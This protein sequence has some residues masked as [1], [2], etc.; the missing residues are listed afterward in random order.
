MHR[1]RT[2]GFLALPL[3]LLGCASLP[4]S[5][6]LRTEA[7]KN[8][9]FSMVLENPKAYVGTI[10]LWGG[11][12]I[13]TVNLKEGTEIFLL[14]TPLDS[15]ER[16]EGGFSSRGRFIAKDSNFLDPAVYKKNRWITLAGEVIGEKTEAL[17][18]TEYTYPVVA[19]K[20]LHLWKRPLYYYP[21]YNPYYYWYGPYW[22][23][24]APYWDWD[25]PYSWGPYDDWDD[26]EE[27]G[28]EE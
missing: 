25:A 22:D 23:W 20:Q 9:T 7:A 28:L 2:L 26:Q 3:L 6:Q 10:V 4:I 13:K 5:K 18:K 12:I 16:P 11:Q 21:Y 8:V 1:Y 24:D 15:Y 19:V 14:E 27:E 17:G